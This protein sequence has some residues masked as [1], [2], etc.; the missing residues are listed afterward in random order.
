MI[1]IKKSGRFSYRTNK[2]HN[3]SRNNNSYSHN[4]YRSKGN[5][6][7]LYDKYTKL[8]KEA[9]SAGDR[10]QAEY[11]HQFADHFSRLMNENGVKP[12]SEENNVNE[13]KK[14]TYK[15]ADEDNNLE[16]SQLSNN[17]NIQSSEKINEEDENEEK[18]NS[19][20]AVSFISQPLKKTRKT[21]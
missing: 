19:L 17:E 16:S 20:E 10:I 5:V 3:Y 15:N 8:A 9:S 14:E 11:Y 18:D 7:A 2:R 12:F 21:K 4:K 13:S 1:S 6:S